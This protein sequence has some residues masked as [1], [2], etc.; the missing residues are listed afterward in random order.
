MSKRSKHSLTPEILLYAY[1]SGL[2]PMARSKNG[3]IEWFSPD[4]RCII[5]FESFHV[6]RS[7]RKVVSKNVFHVTMDKV[8]STVITLCADRDDTWIS[9]EIVSAY[10]Q[11]HELGFAHSVEAW[12][13][14][15]CVGGLYGVAIGSAFFGESMFSSVPDASKV[16]L[17]H[18]VDYL[19]KRGYTLLDSQIINP[20][21][22]Q[23]GAVEISRNDYLGM[24]RIAVQNETTF[25]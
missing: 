16:C 19:A 5:P 24:L 11:L 21:I 6:S 8:F 15:R 2:F 13:D 22:S 25:K 14:E 1:A 3:P 17:V 20:H 10:T 7:L 12:S 9:P 18:L 4:P 23:F